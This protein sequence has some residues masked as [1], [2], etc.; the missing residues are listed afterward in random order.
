VLR[1]RRALG[2]DRHTERRKIETGTRAGVAA[3]NNP[4]RGGGAHH[5]LFVG[6]RPKKA[7]TGPTPSAAA[8][9]RN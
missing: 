1:E 2:D 3:R 5:P 4:P 6:T 8:C 7:T 9:I